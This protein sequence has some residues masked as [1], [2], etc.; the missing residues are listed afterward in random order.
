MNQPCYSDVGQLAAVQNRAGFAFSV[1]ACSVYKSQG[2]AL[3]SW[4]VLRLCLGLDTVRFNLREPHERETSQD[5]PIT[6]FYIEV[7]KI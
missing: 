4:D 2:A 7:L 5:M 6:G 1:T 3:H